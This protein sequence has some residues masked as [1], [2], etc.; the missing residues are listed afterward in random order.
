MDA[1]AHTNTKINIS[2]QYNKYISIFH[3]SKKIIQIY[4]RF[5]NK[6]AVSLHLKEGI[7][8]SQKRFLYLNLDLKLFY[9]TRE[10]YLYYKIGLF[11]N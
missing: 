2:I 9:L 7:L 5:K 1:V 3:N 11:E 4:K 6:P 8:N 10:R